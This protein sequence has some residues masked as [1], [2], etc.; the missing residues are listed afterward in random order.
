MNPRYIMLEP[1]VHGT[2]LPAGTTFRL[3][4]GVIEPDCNDDGNIYRMSYPATFVKRGQIAVAP[5]CVDALVDGLAVRLSDVPPEHRTLFA[6]ACSAL[7]KLQGSAVALDSL[8]GN[9]WVNL[10]P[11]FVE[12]RFAGG[13]VVDWLVARSDRPEAAW[14]PN[15]P[16]APGQPLLLAVA[17][18]LDDARRL[19]ANFAAA[20]WKQHGRN[21]LV[22]DALDGRELPVVFIVHEPTKTYSWWL[23]GAAPDELDRRLPDDVAEA[24]GLGSVVVLGP[25][26]AKE[27]FAP[28]PTAGAPVTVKWLE[29][30]GACAE[31]RR[32]FAETFGERAR[33][34]RDAVAAALRDHRNRENWLH[35]LA[36]HP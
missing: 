30:E 21:R 3:E 28:L 23:L 10:S 14:T 15:A 13:G 19:L 16:V 5:P 35:W 20:G 6:L 2:D 11:K 22:P 24:F 32:W 31:G 12:A 33:V 27:R 36:A 29:R 8:G 9:G 34:S 25:D 4:N 1:D 26:A 7:P 17:K 18:T